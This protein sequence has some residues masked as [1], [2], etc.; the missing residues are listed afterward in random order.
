MHP[1]CRVLIV[2]DEAA[3]SMLI[4]DMVHE[5][6]TEIVGPAATVE[7]AMGLVRS[8]HVDAAILDVNLC[9]TMVFDLADAIRSAGI[10]IVFATGYRSHIIPDRFKDAQIL[11]K[12]FTFDALREALDQALAGSA[13]DTG[14]R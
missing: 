7:H 11:E 14:S 6:G 9:G 5:Y 10:P 12:P 1:R 8:E 4:E 13:C 2:E 3:I